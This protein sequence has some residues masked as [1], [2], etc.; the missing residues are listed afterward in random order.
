MFEQFVMGCEKLDLPTRSIVYKSRWGICL[1]CLKLLDCGFLY[2]G[3][4]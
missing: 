2:E 4:K 3:Y 1:K